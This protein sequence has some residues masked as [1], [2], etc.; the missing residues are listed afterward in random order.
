MQCHSPA[1]GGD[2]NNDPQPSGTCIEPFL[3]PNSFLKLLRKVPSASVRDTRGYHI[4]AKSLMKAFETCNLLQ[5]IVGQ[6]RS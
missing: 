3:S 6:G 4:Y 2:G 1:L 5:G